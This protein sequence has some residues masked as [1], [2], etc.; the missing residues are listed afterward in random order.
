MDQQSTSNLPPLPPEHTGEEPYAE[1]SEEDQTVKIQSFMKHMQDILLTQSRRKGKRRGSTTYTPGDSLTF[2]CTPKNPSTLR[3]QI[4][5]QERPVVKIKAKDHNLNFNGDK[6]EKFIIKE[7]RIAQ[8]EGAREEYLA[9]KIVF[10]TTDSKIIDSIKEITGYEEGNW[11]QLTKA[12]ITKWGRVETE[13]RYRKD[14]L[15]NLFNDTQEEGG[16]STLSQYKRFT[17]E[18]ETILNYLLRYKSIPQ[19]NM[20]HE[21]LFDFL[22]P[23]IKGA[24]SKEMIKE[25]AMVRAEDGEYLLPPMKFLKKY[26]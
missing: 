25:N 1:E 7:E 14:S 10:W 3:H 17:G 12:L 24:I 19:D 21:D 5:L 22:S 13:I 16:I 23:Y 15:V 26:I 4:L 6:V 2:F 20:F 18:Y 9:M 8:I 11:N